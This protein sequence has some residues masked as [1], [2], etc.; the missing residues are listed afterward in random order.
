MTVKITG[1][2]TKNI[3]LIGTSH[4]TNT[5]HNEEDRLPR[6]SGKKVS[7][8]GKSPPQGAGVRTGLSAKLQRMSQ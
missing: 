8:S 4:Q 2:T 6:G 5:F 3:I 7:I 1:K